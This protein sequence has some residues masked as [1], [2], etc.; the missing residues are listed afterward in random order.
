MK[1]AK[2]LALCAVLAALSAVFLILGA[3]FD[4][5]TFAVAALAALPVLLLLAEFGVLPALGSF[6]SAG[7]LALLLAPAKGAALSFLCFFGAYPFFKRIAEKLPR[8]PRVLFKCGVCA[9][10]LLLYA[11]LSL[12]VFSAELPENAALWLAAFALLAAAA[13]FLYDRAL[14]LFLRFYTARFRPRIVKFLK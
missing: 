5:L 14:S 7:I 4:T 10:A 3:F 11:A 8:L 9:G 2:L 12:F 6:L 13:F 1:K